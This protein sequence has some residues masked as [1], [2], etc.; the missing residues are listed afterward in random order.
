LWSKTRPY[1]KVHP[2]LINPSH[3]VP[4]FFLTCVSFRNKIKLGTFLSV[5]SFVTL[6]YVMDQLIVQIQQLELYRSEMETILAN[7]IPPV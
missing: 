6:V 5:K 1:L 4:S 3:Q 7:S 2:A